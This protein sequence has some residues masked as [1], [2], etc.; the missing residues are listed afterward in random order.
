M[1]VHPPMYRLILQK[2]AGIIGTQSCR[3]SSITDT[4]ALENFDKEVAFLGFIFS[5]GQTDN[6]K[7]I[8][9]KKDFFS[10]AFL[11]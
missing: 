3:L 9:K 10:M 2:V 7:A 6:I 11:Y 8:S 1:I 5:D 4:F